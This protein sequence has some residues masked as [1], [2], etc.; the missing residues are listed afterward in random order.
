MSNQSPQLRDLK[1]ALSSSKL[2]PPH[3]TNSI[4]PP[5]THVHQEMLGL[6]AS[7]E[8]CKIFRLK[9]NKNQKDAYKHMLRWVGSRNGQS[10]EYVTREEVKLFNLV[11][12]ILDGGWIFDDTTLDEGL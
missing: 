8:C 2:P 7:L 6:K 9:A 11:K 4:P 10:Q 3:R 12:V 1:L 5:E